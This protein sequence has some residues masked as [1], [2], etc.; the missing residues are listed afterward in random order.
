[1]HAAHCTKVANSN[2]GSNDSDEDSDDND[3]RNDE[4]FEIDATSGHQSLWESAANS[5]VEMADR[6]KKA[7]TT[8]SLRIVTT[9]RCMTRLSC[10]KLHIDYE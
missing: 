9:I 1:M 2:K 5:I 3:D 10:I 7:T 6:K 4:T 8:T